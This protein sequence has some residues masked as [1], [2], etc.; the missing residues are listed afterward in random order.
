MLRFWLSLV[1]SDH[2]SLHIV[3]KNI[4]TILYKSHCVMV[5]SCCVESQG[6]RPFKSSSFSLHQPLN[7][8]RCHY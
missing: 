6:D 4:I 2:G 8:Y 3:D 5:E 7:Y 1:F